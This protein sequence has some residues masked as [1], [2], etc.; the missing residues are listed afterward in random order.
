LYTFWL[1]IRSEDKHGSDGISHFEP[2]WDCE[3]GDNLSGGDCSDVA[4]SYAH[5]GYKV[6]CSF[7]AASGWHERMRLRVTQVNAWE[8]AQAGRFKMLLRC[9]VVGSGTEVE[10]YAKSGWVLSDNK[11]K[12]DIVTIDNTLYLYQEIGVLQIPYLAAD[13][14]GVELWARRT[15]G[16]GSLDMDCIVM[17]PI[18]EAFISFEGANV[19]YAAD[20][21]KIRVMEK[22]SIKVYKHQASGIDA[23][24]PFSVANWQLPRGDSMFVVA[25][26]RETSQGI[27]DNFA[28]EIAALPRWLSLRGNDGVV[29]P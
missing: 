9:K 29:G 12:Q 16:S 14:Y 19:L 13:N 18:D 11:H 17:I 8:Y 26:Q 25:A 20:Q 5:G 15:A 23:E 4:D 3:D 27:N 7:A 22:D 1:G 10:V 21:V 6:N 2:V 24:L 28:L